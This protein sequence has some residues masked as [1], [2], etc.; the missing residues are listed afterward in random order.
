MLEHPIESDMPYESQWPAL[1]YDAWSDTCTTLHLWSQVVGKIRLAT[2]P[3]LNYS[4]H[5]A[6][7]VD[8]SGLTTSLM[9]GAV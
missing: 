5:V 4:W 8:A 1:P 6:L 9:P 3:W 7:Y 2:T